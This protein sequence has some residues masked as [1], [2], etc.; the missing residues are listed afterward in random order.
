MRAERHRLRLTKP[1]RRTRLR[2]KCVKFSF[3]RILDKVYVARLNRRQR[4]KTVFTSCTRAERR[5]LQQDSVKNLL[6]HK[7]TGSNLYFIVTRRMALCQRI[8]GQDWL[9]NLGRRC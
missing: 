6:V 9:L 8:P 2:A 5:S 3:Q 4:S 1:K 7:I